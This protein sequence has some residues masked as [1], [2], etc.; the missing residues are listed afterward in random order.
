MYNILCEKAADIPANV[1]IQ[2]DIEA[3][4]SDLSIFRKDGPLSLS[5]YQILACYFQV[6]RR[7]I[8]YPTGISSLGGL[9][10][11]SMDEMEAFSVF[12]AI[13]NRPIPKSFISS[14]LETSMIMYCT[15]HDKLLEK[16]DTKLC[17]H[18]SKLG[19]SSRNYLPSW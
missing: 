10:L 8:P 11:L 16:F 18:L 13:L 6:F 19:V 9:L 2:K 5:L 7:D 12:S 1:S 17:N 15:I 3:A 4:F 14:K